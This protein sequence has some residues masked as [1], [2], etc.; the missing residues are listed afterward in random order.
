[1]DENEETVDFPVN[2]GKHL[3]FVSMGGHL[4]NYA[5]GGFGGSLKNIA[6]GCAS[7]YKGKAQVHI[8]D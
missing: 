5:M 4:A 1:M 6:I 2:G 7:G 8:L 3:K